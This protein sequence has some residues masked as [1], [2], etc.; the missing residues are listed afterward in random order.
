MFKV[1]V[2]D[3]EKRYAQNLRW[4]IN[5]W[6][7]RSGRNVKIKVFN[8]A[9][10]FLAS[11]ETDG[12]YDLIFLDIDKD[13]V[14]GLEVARQVRE[15]DY[16]ATIIFTSRYEEYYKEAFS[17]HPFQYLTKPVIVQ[18]LEETME[19][20]MKIKER[21]D[22]ET[23][24]FIIKKAQYNL[25]LSDITYFYSRHRHVTAVC[26]E[27]EYTF[28]GKLVD[29]QKQLEEKNCRFLRIHQSYLVNM[30]YIKEYRYS[31]LVLNSG[32]TLGIS[33]E[34]R[35]KMRDIHLMLVD[36]QL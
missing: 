6:A 10:L 22:I 31:E 27:Q 18:K 33:K 20:Y 15:A 12:M 3:A 13:G 21:Q 9:E 7:L 19:D 2:C 11:M 25:R 5:S 29:I 23:F 24:T 32:K 35:K 34:N 28:Y 16:V 8:E 1:A 30:K 4:N 36:I 14:N 26:G 17:A